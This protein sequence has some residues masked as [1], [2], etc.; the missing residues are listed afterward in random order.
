M[1]SIVRDFEGY[2]IAIYSPLGHF[3]VVTPPG[4]NRV[5]DLG[6]RQPRSTVVEG[7]LVC[8]ERAERLVAEL[9]SETRRMSATR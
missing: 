2:R 4:S 9:V 7:P 1:P 5:V 8:L 6:E 3:A